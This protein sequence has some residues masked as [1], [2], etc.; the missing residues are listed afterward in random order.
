M[1]NEI[2]ASIN[3]SIASGGQSVSGAKSFSANLSSTSFIGSEVTVGS[4]TAA[5]IFIGG[6]SNP[7]VVLVINQDTTNFITIDN[8]SA[9]T[10]FPQKLL[11][12]QGILL[13]PESG[14]IFAKADTAPCQAWVV[15]G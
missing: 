11:P 10:N 14:T 12:G 5:S 4:T 2:S 13:C 9:L 8:I 7:S 15:A 1:A 6:L 3:C